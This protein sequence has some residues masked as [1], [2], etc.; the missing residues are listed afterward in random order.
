MKKKKK[1]LE[2]YNLECINISYEHIC[3]VDSQLK[4]HNNLLNPKPSVLDHC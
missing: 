1:K 4:D 2:L 3:N